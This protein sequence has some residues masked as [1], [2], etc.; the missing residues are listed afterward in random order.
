MIVPCGSNL[1]IPDYNIVKA[2]YPLNTRCGGA[3]IYFENLFLLRVHD[4]L[5]PIKCVNYAVAIS[6]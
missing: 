1:E 4:L 5:F 3:C 2:D 6:N